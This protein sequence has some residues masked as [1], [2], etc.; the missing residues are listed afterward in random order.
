VGDVVGGGP[1]TVLVT[2]VEGS[3]ELRTRRGD[4]AAHALLRAHEQVVRAQVAQHGG[5]EVKALGDGFLV[6]FG[7]ARRALACAV[8]IQRAFDQRASQDPGG[9]LR[10]RIG[11]NT[12]EVTE[13]DGDLYG[14]A[15]NATARIG[16]RARGGEILVAD[17][18]RLL[19]GAV[20]EITFRDRGWARLK[21]FPERSHLYEVLWKTAAP[22][23]PRGTPLVGRDRELAQLRGLLE[24]AQRGQGAVVLLAGEPGVGKTRLA[25]EVGALAAERGFRVLLG[26]C[27]ETEGGP[28]YLPFVEIL[29]AAIR[30]V[31]A[32]QLREALGDTAA[33]VARLLPHLRRLFPD[34]PAPLEL[35]PEQERRYLFRSMRDFLARAAN[36]RPQLLILDDVHWADE[37]T[38]LLM[39][40]VAEDVPTMRAL[41]VAT[42]R[43]EE[44]ASRAVFA[45]ALA[46]F[47]RRRLGHRLVLHPLERDGVAAMLCTLGGSEPPAAVVEAVHAETDGNPFF[48]EEVF[49][50]LSESGRL[51]D[52][53]GRFR[54]DVRIDEIDV[55]AGV[56]LVIERRLDRVDKVARTMLACGALAGRS[57]S[58]DLL[59]ALGDLTGDVL[60]DALDEAERAR[61][62]M[63][64]EGEAGA[65][66]AFVHELIRQTVVASVSV[67]RRQSLHLRLA[68]ALQRL[69]ADRLEER[70]A[71]IADHLLAAGTAP[72]PG[73][74]ARFLRLAG[75]HALGASAFED[76]LRHLERAVVVHPAEDSLGRAE[77]LSNL[78]LAHRSLGHIDQAIAT[79]RL[80]LDA[81]ETAGAA[82]KVGRLCV[83][84][85]S[86]LSW[87]G[88]FGEALETASRGLAALGDRPSLHRVRLL[89]S[90]SS[91]FSA[92]GA[93]QTSRDMLGQALALAEQVSDERLLGG[94]LY[95]KLVHHIS[96]MQYPQGAEAGLRSAELL[97]RT[98]ELWGVA[99]VLS[100]A[101]NCL[102]GC[103]RLQDAL[104][105]SM[106]NAALAERLGN[107]NALQQ[108]LW[109][110]AWA[111]MARAGDLAQTE[112]MLRRSIE[113]GDA[114]G[115][116]WAEGQRRVLLAVTMVWRGQWEEALALVRELDHSDIPVVAFAAVG[117]WRLWVEAQCAEADEVRTLAYERLPAAPPPAE[118]R[119]H[120]SWNYVFSAV[121]AFA[122]CG[123]LDD[124]ARL[125]PLVVEA[126]GM[127]A[128]LSWPGRL[129]EMLGGLAAACGREW[130]TAEDHFTKAAQ[131]A[132]ELSMR[133]QQPEIRRFHARMLLDRGAAGDR[134]RARQLLT[135]A[136]DQYRNMD[137]PRHVSLAESMLR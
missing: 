15:V 29:E 89:S 121:E 12:G 23:A 109:F 22:A 131:Q 37:A 106:E 133:I 137:M 52:Q 8:G 73:E 82:E 28:P 45:D 90:A 97:R 130:S 59:E 64:V 4:E 105:I 125:Y 50:H 21:G 1:V 13:E 51:L 99:D 71:E 114:A 34:I 62:I 113:V 58:V 67:A 11:L 33:E 40:D 77:V 102:N 134:E 39:E 36:V 75:E 20:P 127:G 132:V 44:M 93:Y 118:L 57:F 91:V 87:A 104:A 80:A 32:E 135:E 41:V 70:A 7:S 76:A 107:F 96:F 25:T 126:M 65:T 68:R 88:R 2:D 10:V 110:Q 108:S 47:T 42:Y 69:Y 94:V 38:L 92:G 117:P 66:Y 79:W 100:I 85:V 43:E 101:A 122:M 81:F 129:L 18:V 86:Q 103:G 53:S 116:R 56:R 98:G 60:L 46:R 19:A 119:S 16:A 55:P 26:R 17:V 115:S 120:S 128:A 61:L 124:A 27:Y 35:P 14:A 83:G 95:S 24:G 49:H 48:V 3:T 31:P 123:D 136:I 9:L 74:T 78:G 112:A 111:G 84:V 72:E 6:A 30:A 54:S 5:R 63:G